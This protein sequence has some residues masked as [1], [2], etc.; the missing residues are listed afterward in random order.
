MS[1]S[2][3]ALVRDARDLARKLLRKSRPDRWLHT[4]G[5]ADRAAELAGTVRKS[6]RPTLIAAAWLH[7]IGYAPD[8]RSTGFPP[9]DGALYLQDH[10]WDDDIT[11]LIAHHTGAALVP[12][13]RSVRA[14][15]SDFGFHDSDLADALTYANLTVSPRGK[16]MKVADRL[17]D[18]DKRHGAKTTKAQRAERDAYLLA[19]VARV[20]ERLA[21]LKRK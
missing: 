13:K 15:L 7:D 19:V 9:V 18:A 21:E 12:V 14:V 16:R 10:R 4:Q 2:D 20:E 11:T 8:L 3:D 6:R 17:A 1:R 5:V